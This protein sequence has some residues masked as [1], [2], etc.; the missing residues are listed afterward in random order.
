MRRAGLGVALLA[1][2]GCHGPA[3]NPTAP[4]TPP[5]APVAAVFLT[6]NTWTFPEG[7]GSL[8]IVI[9]TSASVSGSGVAPNIPVALRTTSGS[10]S[11]DAVT[12]DF[13]GHA[14]VT[15]SGTAGATITAQAGDLVATSRI[16]IAEP[17]VIPPLPPR[18]PE[19]PIPPPGPGALIVDIIFETAPPLVADA[20]IRFSA[21][22]REFGGIDVPVASYAWNMAGS[23]TPTAST[24]VVTTSY[25]APGNYLVELVAHS[26]DGRAGRS[27]LKFEVFGPTTPF[28]LAVTVAPPNAAAGEPITFTATLSPL[29]PPDTQITLSW[30]FEEDGGVDETTTLSAAGNSSVLHAYPVSG[31]Y[32]TR[33]VAR[34]PDG[35]F[36]VARVTVTVR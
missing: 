34:A 3:P 15:W 20:P 9:T 7:G 14:R 6:P 28:A 11:T 1:L 12:T 24:R 30:D 17:P 29:Q 23:R 8:E 22:V 26:Q 13:T 25:A 5:S 33:V 32:T 10:L 31:T 35:R 2:V 16:T 19:P 27:Q 21:L 4:S 36:T 18:P